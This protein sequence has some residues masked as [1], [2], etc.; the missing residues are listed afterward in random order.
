MQEPVLIPTGESAAD[1]NG[2][3]SAAGPGWD[4]ESIGWV[5]EAAIEK[6]PPHAVPGQPV[7]AARPS[8]SRIFFLVM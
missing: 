6:T 3:Q 2:T 8:R 1:G 7:T 5:A 4:G